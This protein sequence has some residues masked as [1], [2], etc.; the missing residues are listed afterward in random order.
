M[1]RVYFSG[2]M[3]IVSSRV[4]TSL[5]LPKCAR[6]AFTLMSRGTQQGSLIFVSPDGTFG[7]PKLTDSCYVVRSRTVHRHFRACVRTDRFDRNRLFTCLKI[8]TTCDGKAR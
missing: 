2:R 7:V 8:T 3:L 4:R 5:A 1:T 6:P